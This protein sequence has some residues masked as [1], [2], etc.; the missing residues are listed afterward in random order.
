VPSISMANAP[1][2]TTGVI[3]SCM[4]G[5]QVAYLFRGDLNYKSY[6]EFVDV[7]MSQAPGSPRDC[8][9][10]RRKVLAAP[11]GGRLPLH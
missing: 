4:E 10:K 5:A 2:L 9:M 7:P 6:V 1:L 8:P 3:I 11:L